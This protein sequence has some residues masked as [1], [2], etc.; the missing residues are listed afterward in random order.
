MEYR[1]EQQHQD[2]LA[3]YASY[4]RELAASLVTHQC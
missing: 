3:L 2:G 4:A 1:L